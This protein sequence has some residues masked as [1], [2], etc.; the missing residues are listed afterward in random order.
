MSVKNKITK[1]TNKF[2]AFAK[3]ALLFCFVASASISL[4]HSFS[5]QVNTSVEGSVVKVSTHKENFFQKL[6]F[7]HNGKPLTKNFHDCFLCSFS[8]SQ[9][10][11]LISADLFFFTAAFFLVFALR[12]FDRVKL[13]YL[14]SSSY[15]RAPPRR[16]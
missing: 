15:S 3:I 4:L 5:H 1:I 9:N 13:S 8:N 16:S 14:L 12:F 2:T 10:Q 7:S 11:A 6:I